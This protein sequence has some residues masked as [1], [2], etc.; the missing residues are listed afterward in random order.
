MLNFF[1][2]CFQNVSEFKRSFF[3]F[4]KYNLINVLIYEDF[5]NIKMSIYRIHKQGKQNNKTSKYFA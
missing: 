4:W 3:K 1:I 2:N 5:D